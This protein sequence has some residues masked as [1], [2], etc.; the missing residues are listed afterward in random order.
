[1]FVLDNQV[2]LSPHII[3]G[4][5][6]HTL[7]HFK[8]CWSYINTKNGKSKSAVKSSAVTNLTIT[9]LVNTSINK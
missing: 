3:Y 9:N 4:I 7:T 2:I 5:N 6:V 8:N 1:M